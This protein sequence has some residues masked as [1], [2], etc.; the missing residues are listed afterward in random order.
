MQSVC[1]HSGET[2]GH[3]MIQIGHSGSGVVRSTSLLASSECGW[4]KFLHPFPCRLRLREGNGGFPSRHRDLV[5][6]GIERDQQLDFPKNR[7][8]PLFDRSLFLPAT[9]RFT[10]DG[11]RN[12]KEGAI[13]GLLELHDSLLNL[14]DSLPGSLLGVLDSLPDL[15][16]FLPSTAT[17]I[18]ENTGG[19]HYTDRPDNASAPSSKHVTETTL[20]DKV[21]EHTA[22]SAKHP[23]KE[24]THHK[25]N[26]D[27]KIELDDQIEALKHDAAKLQSEGKNDQA[28]EIDREIS[29][30]V[31]EGQQ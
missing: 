24:G 15:T 9:T 29:K 21:E 28:A 16:G 13:K 4:L 31:R 11:G 22:G 17:W 14:Q 27:E 20:A 26:K 30:L 23:A 7:R 2:S 1:V 25:A 6:A 3:S 5:T 19:P 10:G 8:Y 18:T 12:F